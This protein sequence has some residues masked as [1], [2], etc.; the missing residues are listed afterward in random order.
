MRRLESKD[1]GSYRR[2]DRNSRCDGQNG[3]ENYGDLCGRTRNWSVERAL[4][5]GN[6]VA[7]KGH[8]VEGVGWASGSTLAR[9]DVGRTV[10]SV[11]IRNSNHDP[12]HGTVTPA[13]FEREKGCLRLQAPVDGRTGMSVLQ[14]H[15]CSQRVRDMR[16]IAVPYWR[17]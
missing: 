3:V 13:L 12:Y 5:F 14:I 6:R 8:A 2:Y 4:R 10:L 9:C 1:L 7:V 17:W 15:L 16:A 11:R